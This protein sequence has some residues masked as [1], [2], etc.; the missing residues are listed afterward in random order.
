MRVF[1]DV[2]SDGGRWSFDRN[3]FAV[4]T[5]VSD[6]SPGRGPPRLTSNRSQARMP[7]SDGHKFAVPWANSLLRHC[8]GGP[9]ALARGSLRGPKETMSLEEKFAIKEDVRLMKRG[10]C[11]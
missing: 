4:Y 8:P 1:R 5:A 3:G 7:A 6:V 11:L 9:S 2:R 10:N